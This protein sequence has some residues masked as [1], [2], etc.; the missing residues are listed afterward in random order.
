MFWYPIFLSWE[1]V[2]QFY[3]I[4]EKTYA[5]CINRDFSQIRF[6]IPSRMWP[7]LAKRR[8]AAPPSITKYLTSRPHFACSANH[9]KVIE[10]ERRPQSIPFMDPKE[11]KKKVGIYLLYLCRSILSILSNVHVLS[12]PLL[13][14]QETVCHILLETRNFHIFVYLSF[15]SKYSSSNFETWEP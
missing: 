4:S 7:F 13:F 5:F 3:K 9:N 2:F 1:K 8:Y 14:Y 11:K 6:L 10:F 15:C 12:C